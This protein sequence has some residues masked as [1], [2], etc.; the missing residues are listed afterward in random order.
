V[1]EVVGVRHG[2]VVNVDEP[3]RLRHE[4]GTDTA[5]TRHRILGTLSPGGGWTF[6]P[7]RVGTRACT[8]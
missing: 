7:T 1:R 5:Q 2:R 4:G 6:F 8:W 3:A